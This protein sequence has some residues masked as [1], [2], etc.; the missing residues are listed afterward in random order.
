MNRTM[1]FVLFA[2]F[3]LLGNV[4]GKIK[5]NFFMGI[6]T[7]WTLA[8]ERVWH[9]THRYAGRLWLVGGTIGAIAALIGLPFS[10]G[11]GFLLVIAFLPVFKSYFL[12]LRLD[13]LE[14]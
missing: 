9:A 5:R 14:T 13:S 4:M 2:F 10:F 1:M 3:A 11:I 6:R 7:P 8:D 12:Y